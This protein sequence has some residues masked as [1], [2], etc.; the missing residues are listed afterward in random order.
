M[1]PQ[2]K[3]KLSFKFWIECDGKPALGEG[4]AKILEAIEK[5]KSIQKSARKLDMSYRYVWNYL[6]KI[7]KVIG[8]PV[9]EKHRGGKS[10]RGSTTLNKTGG[11]LLKEY[12]RLKE[13]LSVNSEK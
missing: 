5:E 7:E 8:E 9:V 12:T 4:G 10:G 6:R 3:L 13:K 2:K 1:H 11:N